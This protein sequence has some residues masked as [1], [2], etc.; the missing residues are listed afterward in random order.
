MYDGIPF[1]DVSM[2]N[3][4]VKTL[5]QLDCNKQLTDGKVISVDNYGLFLA[6]D[7]G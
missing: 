4:T 1:T 2:K 5:A 6:T 7:S 3:N